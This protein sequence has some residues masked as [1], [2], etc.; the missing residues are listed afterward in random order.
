MAN[1]SMKSKRQE[2][3]QR[4]SDIGGL[5]S[6]TRVAIREILSID[7]EATRNRLETATEVAEIYRL[8]GEARAL[9]HLL[10]TFNGSP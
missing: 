1:D 6:N 3:V 7:V 2:A 5:H 4:L 9:R 10:G 8:Q